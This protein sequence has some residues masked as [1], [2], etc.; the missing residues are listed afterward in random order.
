ML[1]STANSIY[2]QREYF[3][4]QAAILDNNEYKILPKGYITYRSM[5]DTCKFYF[6]IQNIID[7]EIIS[8]AYPSFITD[9]KKLNK[10]KEFKMALCKICLCSPFLFKLSKI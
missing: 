10:I 1:S 8:P 6:N 9:N 7:Y 4:K 5:C 3:N 2:F